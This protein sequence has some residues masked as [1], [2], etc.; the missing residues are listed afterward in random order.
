[1]SGR[2]AV[3]KQRTGLGFDA[4][5]EVAKGVLIS[6][7][8]LVFRASRSGGPGGQNVNKVNTR[9]TLFF[10]VA[11]CTDLS[12]G[13]KR[14]ILRKYPT[15]TDKNGILRVVSQ[16]FRSQRANRNAA[17]EKL[18]WLLEAALRKKP[19]RRPT[20][21]P[22]YARQQR[23]EDKK[24]RSRLKQQRAKRHLTEDI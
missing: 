2:L 4:M 5:I 17:V 10:D 19:A 11:G 22:A 14:R 7:D 1:M 21:V 24:H 12:G 9:V 8:D 3:L 13:Q 6:E 16:K 23:L 18:Q 20:V 15:R